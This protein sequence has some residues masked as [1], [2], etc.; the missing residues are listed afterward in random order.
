MMFKV[1]ICL[2]ISSVFAVPLWTVKTNCECPQWTLD[3]DGANSEMTCFTD[4]IN[5]GCIFQQCSTV[6]DCCNYISTKVNGV[7]CKDI[8]NDEV[9]FQCRSGG[10]D[11]DM[12]HIG[13]S[14]MN[15]I[16][17]IIIFILLVCLFP[18]IIYGCLKYCSHKCDK[19]I[20]DRDVYS[21]FIENQEQDS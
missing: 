6:V 15:E 7:T 2:L 12:M 14:C 10:C 8:G 4:A 18:C 13:G 16:V 20:S 17:V 3:C 21:T 1:S 11:S 9:Y 5:S 19:R